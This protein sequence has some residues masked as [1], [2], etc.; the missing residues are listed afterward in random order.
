MTNQS[1]KARG[2]RYCLHRLLLSVHWCLLDA[3]EE[4]SIVTRLP[5]T[6]GKYTEINKSAKSHMGIVIQNIRIYSQVSKNILSL[7]LEL[8][9]SP[10]I[11]SLEMNL[12]KSSSRLCKHSLFHA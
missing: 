5:I 9:L 3:R 8:N 7:G 6:Q 2:P 1:L 12:F 11:L 4:Y 10:A